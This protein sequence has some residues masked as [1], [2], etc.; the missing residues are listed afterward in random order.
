[1][2]AGSGPA[3]SASDV[4][5]PA[6]AAAG[7]TQAAT[8]SEADFGLQKP[9]E[10]TEGKS[11]TAGVAA[12]S[13]DGYDKLIFELDNGQVWHQVEYKRFPVKAGQVVEIRHG[14]FGINGVEPS[15]LSP[16]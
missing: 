10:E 15:F 5:V 4:I 1:V 11:L 9:R 3:E 14:S 7:A 13:R 6:A 2:P 8:P 16:H 12:V